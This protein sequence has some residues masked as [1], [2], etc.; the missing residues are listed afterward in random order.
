MLEQLGEDCWYV[1]IL[2][3]SDSTYYVGITTNL[4]RRLA[5]HNSGKGAKYTRGRT[6][7]RLKAYFEVETRS[8]A[9]K[10]EILL[11]KRNRKQKSLIIENGGIKKNV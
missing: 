3:C 7:V 8:E 6:P 10:L 1:Y 2:E 5:R 9:L 11:K 4:N